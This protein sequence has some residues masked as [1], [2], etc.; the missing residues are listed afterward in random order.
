MLRRISHHDWRKLFELFD[1]MRYFCYHDYLEDLT[2]KE[3]FGVG[4]ISDKVGHVSETWNC[5]LDK[6]PPEVLTLLFDLNDRLQAA[7]EKINE[8]E[9]K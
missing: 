7:E 9:K 2:R 3:Q 4:K 6:L 8:L 1:E 5:P